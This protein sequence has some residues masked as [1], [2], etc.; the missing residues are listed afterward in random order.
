MIRLPNAT[1]QL[2]QRNE[3]VAVLILM[4]SLVLIRSDA[5]VK[6]HDKHFFVRG[7]IR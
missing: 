1:A 3:R 2:S 5:F 7:S 4:R 6:L